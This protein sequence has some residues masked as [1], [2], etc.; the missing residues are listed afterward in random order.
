MDQTSFLMLLVGGTAIIG[1]C[2]FMLASILSMRKN[3]RKH[4]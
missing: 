1:A 2:F 4:E 3:D